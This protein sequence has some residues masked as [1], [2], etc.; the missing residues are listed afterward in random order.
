[1]RKLSFSVFAICLVVNLSWVSV[2]AQNTKKTSSQNSLLSVLNGSWQ[3]IAV[4]AN[5]EVVNNPPS[6]FRVCHDG[7]FSI[8]GQDSAG[9]WKETY[10]STYEISNNIYKDTMVYSSHPN[11]IGV[12]HWQEFHIKG[13]T[14]FFK[15]FQKLTNLDGTI[16]PSTAKREIVCVRVKRGKP[17][18]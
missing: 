8:V 3:R 7:F 1:M 6:Q 11:V 18:N 4:T 12:I 14:I 9:A 15:L 5:G 10:G 16:I 17:Q 2:K 13:D